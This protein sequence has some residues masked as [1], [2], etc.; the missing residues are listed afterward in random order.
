MR[1]KFNQRCLKK[2]SNEDVIN[3]FQTLAHFCQKQREGNECRNEIIF[4]HESLATRIEKI[5]LGVDNTVGKFFTGQVPWSPTIQVHRDRLDYWHRILQIKTGVLTSKNHIKRLS[6][7][8]KEY[9]GH[10]LST[11]ASIEKLK[12]AWKEYQVATKKAAALRK[13]FI[14]DL[15]AKKALYKKTSPE[16]SPASF[17]GQFWSLC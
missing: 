10:Y 15:I 13:E 5:Q 3:D 7:K 1:E 14:E 11:V 6:I 4:L 17:D 8:L 9:S 16:A 12:T 2:Y